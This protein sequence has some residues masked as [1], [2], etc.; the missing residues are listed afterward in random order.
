MENLIKAIKVRYT[1]QSTFASALTGGIHLGEDSIEYAAPYC[2]LVALERP[3]WTFDNNFEEYT[4]VFM[5]VSDTRDATEIM[6]LYEKLLACFDEAQLS[7]TGYHLLR[8]WR[9]ASSNLERV[10]DRWRI[11]VEYSCLLEET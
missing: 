4:V 6:N 1:A 11:T 2:V 5:L 8:F 9:R 7:V 3:F 10:D